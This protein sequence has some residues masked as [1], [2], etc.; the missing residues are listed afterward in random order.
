MA[1]PLRKEIEQEDSYYLRL[2]KN[3]NK[4]GNKDLYLY[5]NSGF[6][7][8]LL[9]IIFFLCVGVIINIGLRIQNLNYD[10]KI[11]SIEQI[12]GSEKERQD[13]LELE[14]SQLKSPLRITGFMIENNKNPENLDLADN[15]GKSSGINEGKEGTEALSD[16]VSGDT[17][18]KKLDILYSKTA[19]DFSV[20]EISQAQ[21]NT[22]S[23]LGATAVINNIKDILMVV[24]EGILT[25]F[26]P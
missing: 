4:S 3:E 19:N 26:I 20:S 22:G 25:F 6:F 7:P 1:E 12:I 18:F 10:K 5:Y 9:I 24:S 21:A 15:I 8:I 16:T 2:I 11:Y 14:I 23:I 13:R 17:E